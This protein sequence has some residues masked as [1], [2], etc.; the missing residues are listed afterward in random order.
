M[1]HLR[2]GRRRAE[3]GPF[4]VAEA[5]AFDHCV[6]DR[7]RHQAQILYRRGERLGAGI[8]TARHDAVSKD[9]I[10]Q[11][12]IVS[13]FN[14]AEHHQHS[15]RAHGMYASHEGFRR[16][17]GLNDD[18]GRASWPGTVHRSRALDQPRARGARRFERHNLNIEPAQLE[19]H[20]GEQ[21]DG[22]CSQDERMLGCALVQTECECDGFLDYAQR[23][24]QHC[25]LGNVGWHEKEVLNAIHCELGEI[26]V[27]AD[28]ATL[29]VAAG[30]A[31]I[32]SSPGTGSAGRHA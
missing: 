12:H 11:R 9:Q 7:T 14:C 28:D 15:E 24:H 18:V 6:Q 31:E 20:G 5:G 3:D 19:H 30:E 22:A 26:S 8:H 17:R 10:D 25:Y 13:A 32:P 29:R 1:H 27:F 23:L 16:A 2:R 4:V 21:S